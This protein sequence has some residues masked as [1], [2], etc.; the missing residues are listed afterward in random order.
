MS[1]HSSDTWNK[2]SGYIWSLIGSA[3]GFAN[4]L[5]FSAQ[6]Y[7]NGGGAFLIPYF[8]ALLSLGVPMLLL[9]GL[10]GY[11]W[12]LPVVS[13]YGKVLGKKGKMLGWLAILSCMTI[14]GFYI[15]LTGYSVAYT[16]FAA[17]N[18]IP[19]D[20]QAFFLHS[21][22]NI[23]PS[24]REF[25]SL[26]WTILLSTVAV[27]TATWFVLV[28]NVKDGIEKICTLFMPLMAFIMTLLA[29]VML[30]LPGGINGL[31]FY[32][33][34]DFSK[35]LDPT[36]W[37]DVFGQLFFSLSLGLGIIVGYSRHTGQNTN[38]A[39][40]MIWVGLGDFAV[41][42]ISG[43]AIFGCLAHV[44]YIQQIPFDAIL[45]TDSTFDIGFILF[46]TMLKFFGTTLSIVM[47][48]IF[49]TC[50]FIAGITGVFS[51]VES[52][53]GNFEVEFAFSR[54]KA[55]TITTAILG[56][57]GIAF[58]MGNGSHIIDALAPMVLGI[59]MLIGGLALI[60][61]FQYAS[62]TTREDPLWYSGNKLTIYAFLLRYFAPC[63]L[64]CIL[65]GNLLQEFDGFDIAKGVRWSWLVGALFFSGFLTW[66]TEF[67][68]FTQRKP[69]F[70]AKTPEV[71]GSSE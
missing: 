47:G 54:K 20:S 33:K 64:T 12:K 6:V 26:S 66:S 23:T 61:T 4:V 44:S 50:I 31:Y 19:D 15:V 22:L 25:G 56:M 17:T 40:A 36:L 63:V 11:Q 34:P 10:I 5:A 13:A 41:S 2:Q 49:F 43:L 3:V 7:K 53:A 65:V 21:F 28:R 39:R 29:V 30:C 71:I 37:R 70:K 62:K 46:P 48:V 55:V 68:W 52:I 59:N 14:G 67:S 16:Y 58:C 38:I 9:E 35:L 45:S 1:N 57:F 18:Q 42:F 24:I 32:L 51:I 8:I 60:A 69:L 27:C